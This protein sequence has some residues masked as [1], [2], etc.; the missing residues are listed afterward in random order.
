M[1]ESNNGDDMVGMIYE[2]TRMHDDDAA[3]V[4]TGEGN[5]N[6]SGTGPNEDMAKYFKMLE[7]AQ[8][9]LYP[10][11]RKFTSLSFIVRLYTVRISR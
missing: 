4:E 7:D 1:V 10:G 6:D 9:E 8:S 3:R 2:A 5:V 11:C